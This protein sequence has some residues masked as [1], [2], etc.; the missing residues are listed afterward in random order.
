MGWR[1]ACW[2]WLLL[3]LLWAVASAALIIPLCA[4]VEA[5]SKD[6]AGAITAA[7]T[8]KRP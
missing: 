3:A 5:L 4:A 1:E 8:G 7:L 6:A 2:Q